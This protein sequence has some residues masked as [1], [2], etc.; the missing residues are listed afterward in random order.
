MDLDC[1]KLDI[2]ECRCQKGKYFMHSDDSAFYP[3]AGLFRKGR[4]LYKVRMSLHMGGHFWHWLVHR[5]LGI[6]SV[7]VLPNRTYQ[8]YTFVIMLAPHTHSYRSILMNAD[9]RIC[10]VSMIVLVWRIQ[11]AMR[12]FLRRRLEGKFLAVAM[13]SHARLGAGSL[14]ADTPGDVWAKIAEYSGAR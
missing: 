12:Q 4:I 3:K 6:V 7:T 2:G 5:P 8:N 14:W 9:T 10:G 1:P 11:R 13:V